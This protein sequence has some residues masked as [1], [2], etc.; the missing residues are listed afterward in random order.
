MIFMNKSETCYFSCLIFLLVN[1]IS[2][3]NGQDHEEIVKKPNVLMI[4]IDD[5]ND[6]IGAMGYPSKDLTPN[7]DRLASKGVL[8][9]NA[10][11]QA[12]LCG[13]SRASIM[14]GLRPST[15]GIYGMIGDNNIK[16]AVEKLNLPV[17]LLPEYFRQ[18]GYK[19]MGVGKIFHTHAPDGVLDESGGRVKGFGPVPSE[20]FHWN[21][22]KTSTDWGAFPAKDE[23]MADYKSANWAIEKLQQE[24]EK[25]FF[26]AVGFL[27]P[28]VPWYVP[29]Q[30]FKKHPQSSVQTPPY[31][32]NDMDD[33]PAI[34]AE[35]ASVPM[36]PTTEWA[37]ENGQWKNISQ[38]YLA[39]ISF[40]DNYVGQVLETLENSAYR[41]NT[42]IVL[43]SDH[44][45]HLGEK[46][47]FAKHSLW[48]RATKVP[49][50][51]AGTSLPQGKISAQPV[52]LLD[53]YPTLLDLAGL[54]F[55]PH[56]EGQSLKDLILNP[57]SERAQPAIT[58]YGRNN[59]AIR[60]KDYRYIRYEDGSEELYHHINDENE[61]HNVAEKREYQEVKRNLRKYLPKVNEKWS[62][63]SIY[64]YNEYLTRQR[65]EQL[66]E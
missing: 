11:C 19:T 58:T 51:I 35:L 17:T 10:H 12:P 42:I 50:I 7:I 28:H 1:I 41:D 24:H 8:F 53:I 61:W 3:V 6:W 59:H 62:E 9:N 40:V 49:L 37:I 55:N 38:A 25:P 15:T 31:L 56:I 63:S 66:A 22:Q 48:E 65:Q 47:R 5:L 27:R 21:Q 26:L 45:Y 43:W 33:V 32:P 2:D 16:G 30:W 14:T 20:R 46:N 36:M 60:N 64:N 39:C 13:P 29:E 23:E 4:S 34:G 52:E 44:G 18:H 54:P 57:E